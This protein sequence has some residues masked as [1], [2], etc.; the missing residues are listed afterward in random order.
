MELV[1][2]DAM[3]TAIQTCHSVDEVTD[4]RNKAMA[5]EA[6]AKQ[7]MNTDAERQ[8][9]AIRLR[10][11]RKAGQ[12]LA[13][14]GRKQGNRTDI[15]SGHA[16]PK[17]SDFQQAKEQACISDTQAK[18]WQNLSKV[19]DE[20]FESALADPKTKP[21]TSGLIKKKNGRS[22]KM[23]DRALSLWG[24]LRDIE[25]LAIKPDSYS[26]LVGEMTQT[27]VD[28]LKRITPILIDNL[29]ELQEQIDAY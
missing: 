2:Y 29:N 16:E 3:C 27:M 17:S 15:T 5:L 25:G 14:K 12:L 6:Y 8:A 24:R 23:D 28:D 4:I 11:E 20:E 10:A 7:A 9:C 1:K 26:H 13:E 21:S 19:P 22:G 18:R